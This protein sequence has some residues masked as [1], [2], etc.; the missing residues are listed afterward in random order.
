MSA[1]NE[2]NGDLQRQQEIRG[3]YADDYYRPLLKSYLNLDRF[4]RYRLE[5][6][7]EIYTPGKGERVLDLG[8]GVGT[9]SLELAKMG[10]EVVGLD[11]SEESISICRRLTEEMNLKANYVLADVTSTGLE[12]NSFDVIICA[13]L[14]EHLYD[15]VFGRLIVEA[16]RLLRSTGKFLIWAPNP[17]HLFE[18][19]K[20]RNII[21]KRDEGH[22]GYRSLRQIKEALAGQGFLIEKAYYRESH[23]P[24]WNLV[25]RIFQGAIPFLRR[26]IAVLAVK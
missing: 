10:I 1:I 18:C 15:A 4:S 2:N 8:C 20:Q 25:E 3:H 22:V 19:L 26:R 7:F 16:R 13:D 5:K 14:V 12:A 23:L 6:V 17:G 24:I 9:F 11:Y 21:L